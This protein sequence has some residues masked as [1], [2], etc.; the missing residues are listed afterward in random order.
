MPYVDGFVLPVPRMR[1]VTKRMV[2][3]SFKVLVEV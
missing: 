1:V 3:G 2:Y